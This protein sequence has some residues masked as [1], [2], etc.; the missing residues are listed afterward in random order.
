MISS[1]EADRFHVKRSLSW[2]LYFRVGYIVIEHYPKDR[3]D[4]EIMVHSLVDEIKILSDLQTD[5]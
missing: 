3:I 4:L 1:I 2:I 5:I